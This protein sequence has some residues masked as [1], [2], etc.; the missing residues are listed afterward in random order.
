MLTS[1]S[2]RSYCWN[3]KVAHYIC[4]WWPPRSNK[5][6]S[7]IIKKMILFWL[8]VKKLTYYVSISIKN[9]DGATVCRGPTMS[10]Y[11]QSI[12]ANWDLRNVI[13]RY[14]LSKFFSPS[15]SVSWNCLNIN[16]SIC[17]YGRPCNCVLTVSDNCQGIRS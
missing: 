6:R 1:A 2:A 5:N 16:K 17:V 12:R 11:P 4:S 13:V 14:P 9:I 3:I 15:M 8:S 10:Y 7:F